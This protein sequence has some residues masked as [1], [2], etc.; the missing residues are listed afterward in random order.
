MN[1]PKNTQARM[2]APYERIVL[3]VNAE[4]MAAFFDRWSDT[5]QWHPLHNRHYLLRTAGMARE[6]ELRE[7]PSSFESASHAFARRYLVKENCILDSTVLEQNAALEEE[8]DIEV[9]EQEA[10]GI[11]TVGEAAEYLERLA[12]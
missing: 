12:E 1:I 11:R 8:F 4:K 9:D 5:N 2:N 10:A 3:W 6:R 7:L